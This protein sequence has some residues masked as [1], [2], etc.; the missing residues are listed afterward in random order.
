MIKFTKVTTCGDVSERIDIEISYSTNSTSEA[1]SNSKL[2]DMIKKLTLGDKVVA[3]KDA[4][5]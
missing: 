4:K 3:E 5:T 1:I 2:V